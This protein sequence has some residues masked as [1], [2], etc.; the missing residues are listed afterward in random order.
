[1][2]L[3]ICKNKHGLS[4]E[5]LINGRIEANGFADLLNKVDQVGN[6]YHVRKFNLASINLEELMKGGEG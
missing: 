6:T 2:Y 5:N 4:V 3:V 1:M